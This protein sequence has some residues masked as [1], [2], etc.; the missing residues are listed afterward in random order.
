MASVIMVAIFWSGHLTMLASILFVVILS[1]SISHSISWTL[2]TYPIISVPYCLDRKCLAIAPAAT[3]PIVSL[4]EDRPPPFQ[5]RM[6][7]LA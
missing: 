5:L 7:Y 2:F 3:L 1:T 4:A 6:P